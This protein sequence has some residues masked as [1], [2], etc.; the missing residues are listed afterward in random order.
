MPLSRDNDE[1]VRIETA[2]AN[3]RLFSC[4]RFFS[5]EIRLGHYWRRAGVVFV[6][7]SSSRQSTPEHL[8]CCSSRDR[9]RFTFGCDVS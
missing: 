7:I 9:L 5:F 3:A 4:D 8:S 6:M 1:C 2:A